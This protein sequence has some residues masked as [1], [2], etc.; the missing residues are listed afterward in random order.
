MPILYYP[1][2]LTK[3]RTHV[4][5]KLQKPNVL[6]SIFGSANLNDGALSASIWC[7]KSWEV[8]RVSLG[9]GTNAAKTY[10]VSVV[11]GVGV[12]AGKN[13]RLWI[14]TPT[15]SWQKVIMPEGF[16]TS[17]TLPAALAAV[18][19]GSSVHFNAVS[20][21][22]AVTI[23]ISGHVVIT[24]NSGNAKMDMSVV[25]KFGI[26][27]STFAADLGFTASTSMGTPLTADTAFSGLGTKVAY[28][29]GAAST[30]Q[31]IMATDNVAMTIDDQLLIEASIAPASSNLATYEVIYTLL[32]S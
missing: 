1:D 16:Y 28:V 13:D 20:K 2:E 26:P 12:V 9:F 27:N 5:D 29:A 22:F 10:S 3:M 4:V 14:R 17:A 31:S 21:P 19:N 32:D 15:A 8:K 18:L 23:D 25:S 24:P 11:R 7:P 6:H 30:N